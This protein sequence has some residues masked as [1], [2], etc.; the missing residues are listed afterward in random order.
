M[1]R[2]VN[3]QTGEVLFLVNNQWTP[4][5]QT[6]KNP[7]TGQS[8]Y[9]VNNEWQILDPFKME[10]ESGEAK[11]T[12]P[13]L[14]FV[15]RGAELIG[16]GV[17]AVA[18]VGERLGD[19]LELAMPLS[20]LTPEQVKNEQQLKPLF[21]FA[22]SLEDFNKNIGYSPSTKLSDLPGN[23]LKTIPFVAERVITSTPDMAAA[24]AA[25]PAY[26]TART[27][28]ILDER[29]KNDNKTLDDAT[30]GDV[31][32]A[33]GAAAFETLFERFA[34]GRLLPGG[35]A[36]GKTAPG[37]IAKETGIQSGT[38]FAE[39]F[40][41]YAAET[42]G[43][44]KGFDL[45]EASLAGLEGA[46]VGG[47]LGATVQTS[48]E[49]LDAY[50]RSKDQ[51][52]PD[53]EPEDPIP[54]TPAGPVDPTLTTPITPTPVLE[55]EAA[56][57]PAP[58]IAPVSQPT[59][60]QIY[61]NPLDEVTAEVIA[62][63]DNRFSVRMTDLTTGQT[64]DGGTFDTAD[65]ANARAAQSIGMS[66]KP[67]APVGPVQAPPAATPPTV[68]PPTVTPPEAAVTPPAS[69]PIS[70]EPVI[71]TSG[72]RTE[73]GSIYSL[74][75]QG[76][77][78]RTKVSEGKGKGTT[79]DP[80]AA[81]YVKPEDAQSIL[82]D[83]QSGSMDDSASVRLGYIDVEN[84][85]F[86]N[87]TDT[88]QIPAGAEAVVGVV[89]KN[90]NQ[91]IGSYKAQLTPAVGLSPVEKM[92]TPD[93]M[94]NTHI[95]NKIV[96]LFGQATPAATPAVEPTV[97]PETPPEAPPVS[98][99]TA[100]EVQVDVNRTRQ[101][102]RQAKTAVKKGTV[103]PE[104]VSPLEAKL[105]ALEN[106]LSQ[107]KAA[108][109]KAAPKYRDSKGNTWT[110]RGLQPAWLKE[111]LGEGREI[112]EF[113]ILPQLDNKSQD[114]LVGR[115]EFPLIVPDARRAEIEQEIEDSL[116]KIR[117]LERPTGQDNLFTMLR[118]KFPK[119]YFKKNKIDISE[120]LRNRLE[121]DTGRSTLDSVVET[122]NL[123]RFFPEDSRIGNL[124]SQR[125]E[126]T[127]RDLSRELD[128]VKDNVETLINKLE[129]NDPL[130]EDTNLLMIE[131]DLRIQE[132]EKELQL[133][134]VNQELSEVAIEERRIAQQIE[135]DAIAEQEG[136]AASFEGQVREPEQPDFELRGQTQKELTDLERKDKT[137]EAERLRKERETREMVDRERDAF[138][139]QPTTQPPLAKPAAPT[140]DLFGAKPTRE[141]QTAINRARQAERRKQ[142]AASKQQPKNIYKTTDGYTFFE[143]SDGSIVDNID[144]E[145]VDLSW[146]S[147]KEFLSDMDGSAWKFGDEV[148]LRRAFVKTGLD[149]D[150][151]KLIEKLNR[152][153]T[154]FVSITNFYRARREQL[155]SAK[156][157]SEIKLVSS[158]REAEKGKVREQL[159]L[160]EQEPIS[161][162]EDN[163]AGQAARRDAVS[164]VDDLQSTNNPLAMALSKDYAARQRVTL[165]GQSVKSYDDLAILSQVYRHPSFESVR[166]FFVNDA[167]EVVSQLGVTSR[168][169][170][171]SAAIMG[172]DGEEYVSKVQ[173][174]AQ[175]SG[176]TGVWMLHNH[177]SGNV[178][179]SN[180]DEI[181]T[182]LFVQRF[183]K[184]DY[185]GH[186]IIDTNQYSVISP[187]GSIINISKDMSQKDLVAYRP[188]TYKQILEPITIAKR[189]DE[190]P[191][192][193]VII[194]LNNDA[195]VTG[196]TTIDND[197]FKRKTDSQIRRAFYKLAISNFSS[198]LLVATRDLDAL[199]KVA[200]M[201]QDGILIEPNGKFKG[202]TEIYTRRSKFLF[203]ISRPGVVTTDSSKLFDFLRIP[204]GKPR[205]AEYLTWPDI[206]VLLE[207]DA[208]QM[209]FQEPQ[210][211]L[212]GEDS[213]EGPK[214]EVKLPPGRSSELADLA[215]KIQTGE[216]TREQYDAAVNKHAPIYV[217]TSAK[218]PATTKQMTDALNVVQREKVNAE[219]PDGTKIGSRL[220]IDAK[221]KYGV[222]IAAMHEAKPKITSPAAGKALSYRSTVVLKNVEF[223]IGK[224]ENSLDIAAGKKKNSLQTMEGTLVNMSPEE[225]FKRAEKAMK[226][227]DYVQVGFDPIRHS[228]FYD[229]VTTIPVL[230]ADEV[231]QIGD[232]VLAKNP[233][234]GRKDHFLYNI[235]DAQGEMF[236]NQEN[237]VLK[238]TDDV[239]P[240]GKKVVTKNRSPELTAAAQ[241][242]SRGE[243]TK[244]EYEAAVQRFSPVSVYAEPPKP[245]SNAQVVEA[246][247]A[248]KKK[249]AN[250]N[251][252]SGTK[253][254]LRLDIPAWEN[255]KTWVVAIHEGKPKI[256]SPKA[257]KILSYR[258]V[259]AL[260]N[261]VFGIGNQTKTLAI[262]AG[263][264]KDKL[265][266]MEG[267]Y[268]NISPD[269]AYRRAQEFI[270]DPAYIQVGFNPL[271][272]A[273]FYDRRTMLPVVKA[274]EVLQIGNLILAKNAT[275][276]TKE[277]FLFNI[278]STPEMTEA[279]I[280]Q[281]V[282]DVREEQ[283][284][285][286]AR[287]R[288]KRERLVQEVIGGANTIDTQR[289]LTNLDNVT[290]ALKEDIDAEYTPSTSPA[291]FLNRAL[292]AFDKG[293]MSAEVLATIQ[294]AYNKTPFILNGLRLSIKTPKTGQVLKNEGFSEMG[295]FN[296][297]ERIV[298]LWNGTGGVE[299]PGTVRHEL[300]HSLEQ[301]MTAAQRKVLV[302]EYIK[303]FKKASKKNTD[304][305]S[306]L[307]FKKV[308][309]FIDNPSQESFAAAT[310]AM[311]SYDFYQYINP[312]EYWAVN[313]ETLMASKL[314]TAWGRFVT[315]IKKYLEAL[316]N[317][318]GFNNRYAVHKI[319]DQLMS[320]KPK[321]MSFDVLTDFVGNT[322]ARPVT[323]S[324]ISQNVFGQ[325]LPQA[326]WGRPDDSKID[327]I[328]Y[329][330]QDKQID[331]K[332]VV[333]SIKKS[334]KEIADKWNP[335]LQ[336]E[337][338]HGRT[339][340][341]TKDFL[342]KELAPLMKELRDRDLT[343]E[344]V[345]EY[346][347]N[348]HAKARNEFN[349]K[350]DP[351]MPDG[352]SGILTADAQAYLDGLDPKQKRNL[353]A[354]AKLVDDIVNKTQEVIVSTGQESQE[355]V[356]AWKKALT[357]YVPLQREET[358]YDIKNVGI[359]VG[360][361]FA[362]K[363]P[364]SRAAVG[365]SRKVV[366]ILANLAAQRERAIVRG[367]KMRV[368]KALYG[369]V[370]SN[371]NPGFWLAFDPEAIKNP[372]EALN[373]LMSLG[374]K[375]DKGEKFSL[376]DLK[377][378]VSEPMV[379][380]VD[381][382]TNQVVLKPNALL[383]NASTT[384]PVRI[385][386]KEKYIIF[387]ANDPRAARMAKEMKNLDADQ[388]SRILGYTQQ[389]TQYFAKIN[390]Q[391]NPIF[392]VINFARDI[393]GAILQLSTTP[394]RYKKKE[395]LSGVLG[396]LRG[397]YAEE[398]LRR[399]GKPPSKDS[400]AALWREFQEQGGQTGFRDQFSRM[401]DR[402]DALQAI[403]DPSSWT[404]SPLGKVFTAGGTL[405]VPLETARK[406]AAPVF[407]WLSDYNQTM[408][409]AVRLS[410]YK[411][412]K[413]QKKNGVREITDQQAASLAKNLTVN[414]NRKGQIGRQ[415]G[416]LYAFFNA[417]VQGTARMLETLRGPAGKTIIGGG[418]LIGSAQAMLLAAFGFDEDEPPDFVKERNIVIPTGGGKYITVPMPLGYNVIPNTSRILT[419]WGLSGFKDT[420]KRVAQI[421]GAALDMF[422]PIGNAGWSMQTLTPT[423]GDPLVA[424]TENRDWTGKPIA[425]ED[426]SNLDPTPGYS[427]SKET[428]SYISKA[429]AKFLNF[430]TGGTDY[431]PGGFSPTPDQ[432][433]FLIGQLTGGVGRELLKAEQ[434][435]TSQ[436]TGEE[437]PIYKVPLVGRF[438]GDSEGQAAERNR[439]YN[440]I[441]LL[442]KHEREIKG[443]QKDRIPAR[444]YLMEYP[445]ARLY[446]YA[447][448]V[449]RNIRTLR[450]RR[451]ALIE[452]DAP[453][454]RVKQVE[455]QMT[456]QMK[457]FNERVKSA[458]E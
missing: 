180:A 277:D 52:S 283:I 90:K 98:T 23:P 215:Q 296:V 403:L 19:K 431:T 154:D 441:I 60:I 342:D 214:V 20:N 406:I 224:Q 236:S 103:G 112:D 92:Y 345:E 361:G 227:S 96:E 195:K 89:D 37:R 57:A 1:Q 186:V 243:I 264:F 16:S 352:G 402:A 304:A 223:G 22:K 145:K 238:Q 377:S 122:G 142:T 151:K 364:F 284:A 400:Y 374:L 53:A 80:H 412:A 169:P 35:G 378:F 73:K 249:D 357:N 118:G 217:F 46:I 114:E 221:R 353:E 458:Q 350:R 15:G 240:S 157:K 30:I 426:I 185:K 8:A 225:A 55:Q 438:V 234:F 297:F 404:K 104:F 111:A 127:S 216:A 137:G 314:G 141:E 18:E 107:V 126:G 193:M 301:M 40:G 282:T 253:V 232:M 266:T 324:N 323:L 246:L 356:D 91:L 427:R 188:E 173:T 392:G 189:V 242:L 391:Y 449:E 440:N 138:T 132:L 106:E 43:T 190:N 14:G 121:S 149:P 176:A 275:Y 139:L 159:K 100:Q 88:S 360:S 31:S 61:N 351:N 385:N 135:A 307:Y 213:K 419:E 313:A 222:A 44:K 93:G 128:V 6:A 330:L 393:Q 308:L 248:N 168:L 339:A 318:F 363:G 133:E 49:G 84:N 163:R 394:L 124:A 401:Q 265:Q 329:T 348:R 395:V 413:E 158:R 390:T 32:T 295:S 407:D 371:P 452:Q 59:P 218:Q 63:P 322:G 21:D 347:H 82:S 316:K 83:M 420:H 97:T 425:K 86:K 51:T 67:I 436:F 331:T 340:T 116:K 267:E 263:E 39:E 28:E 26:F 164:T 271:R 429:M 388:L 258:S 174:A 381:A 65:E 113:A 162:N 269:E 287:L 397:I 443:R 79:Y 17:E 343:M 259:A 2:A 200:G 196:I 442:N 191:Q 317:V 424:L 109:R 64:M 387:N 209:T 410:A 81:L 161:A 280:S 233:K 272:H 136:T 12:N 198:R 399:A 203:P 281:G 235:G 291:N 42:A 184:L 29:V 205:G 430:A 129:S 72:F 187:T 333:E 346:L 325:P 152:F 354:V 208:D 338:Y 5:S 359:G 454:E 450:K 366:D 201:V 300:M 167:G 204:K 48:K 166:M 319:F 380:R 155:I 4:P 197:F 349:A 230:A 365:S 210:V 288:A 437:L 293:D 150:D 386:G 416:A 373:D 289:E 270:K 260:E 71:P 252:E 228:Y 144:P 435:I 315:A 368:A 335:Y 239:A 328:I 321:R 101:Q 68:A 11:T 379:R 444:D 76:R 206:R 310:A 181:L 247:D 382:A 285:E 54:T 447:N 231:I 146:P 384:F 255:K 119:G 418:L 290:K 183:N 334:G 58:Q 156:R 421:T 256:T 409:N 244:E 341:Q 56:I 262:A 50:R 362:V 34:V 254:G 432:I 165:V 211:E 220:D 372:Q 294:E 38:E 302:E 87:I 408:E 171:S 326:S 434:S 94:S 312:S 13:F 179:P 278:D 455:N 110:G 274:D 125:A 286:Y 448:Q 261:V 433:D 143:L 250:V 7:K 102:I 148:G 212:F 123:D 417:A 9:L 25:A 245:A 192:S 99:R 115:S 428:A 405:K 117:S 66:T 120:S 457:R 175:K 415:A 453:K 292:K 376:E 10:Q 332:R 75:E 199:D 153:D 27:K 414:F 355:T 411:V 69:A 78:S 320:D 337:L 327:N 36:T 305:Q 398:R 194:A 309:D 311:P 369:L 257:D 33:A 303:D 423:V 268:V 279:E 439:F 445:E 306:Q 273:Y 219:I 370:A 147:V 298:T 47:G 24:F 202:L 276:G 85:V 62:N 383:K 226:D 241:Q 74:D 170:G 237:K 422:N 367:E 182:R 105:E 134:D 95:G 77:T 160:F 207:K 229:R 344:V 396:A 375:N 446:S 358:D 45:E 108:P 336:E 299:R 178:T 451:D 251:I 131:L 3:P 389:I 172:K 130:S 177:P 70:Q 456:V 41:T 140:G